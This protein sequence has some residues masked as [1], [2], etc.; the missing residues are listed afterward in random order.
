MDPM[1]LALITMLGGGGLSALGSGLEAPGR[2]ARRERD[3]QG[4]LV[5]PGQLQLTHML[6]GQ[7]GLDYG[8]EFDRVNREQMAGRSATVD[9]GIADRFNQVTGGPVLQQMRDLAKFSNKRGTAL[10]SNY[11]R[12]GR[13]LAADSAANRASLDS[14]GAGAEGIARQFGRGRER[15][16]RSDAASRLTDMDDTARASLAASGLSNSSAVADRLTGNRRDVGRET[17]RALTDLSMATTDRVMDARNNRIRTMQD[18]GEADLARRY[19]WMSGDTQLG[20]SNLSRNL[21]MRQAPI[22]TMLG[23]YQGGVMNPFL[24]SSFNVGQ[25]NGLSNALVSGGNALAGIGAASFG[26]NQQEQ[27][28]QRLLR[29]LG[30]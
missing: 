19:N 17:D 11:Q 13:R 3:M 16:I 9:T 6:T 27:M 4:Q 23:T 30:G 14:L 7:A 20:L 12:Q 5:W 28:M 25:S 24:G 22:D 2:P 18:T 8:R 1:T 15:V 26:A 21:G 29:M 10:R